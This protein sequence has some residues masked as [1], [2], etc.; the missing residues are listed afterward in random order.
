M[1]LMKVINDNRSAT[2]GYRMSELTNYYGT[3]KDIFGKE[4][5]KNTISHQYLRKQRIK[6]GSI[7]STIARIVH[8]RKVRS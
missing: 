2:K 8:H 7:T 6:P 1:H 3:S 4:H 5:T